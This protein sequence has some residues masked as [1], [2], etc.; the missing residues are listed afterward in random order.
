MK[1]VGVAR[2]HSDGGGEI[3]HGAGQI[4]QPVARNATIIERERGARVHRERRAVTC[5][6]QLVLAQLRTAR[7]MVCSQ[8]QSMVMVRGRRLAG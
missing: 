1:E 4:V 3:G 2:V 7:N 5:D 8:D 6:R